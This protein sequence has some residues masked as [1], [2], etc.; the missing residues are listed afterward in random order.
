MDSHCIMRIVTSY[1][2]ALF[3]ASTTPL[4]KFLAYRATL[5]C[6]KTVRCEQQLFI[7][8]LYVRME[9]SMCVRFNTLTRPSRVQCPGLGGAVGLQNAAFMTP[10]SRRD[11]HPQVMTSA[12]RSSRHGN[13]SPA[14]A[15][16]S[17]YHPH[18]A[19]PGTDTYVPPMSPNHP[20]H[21]QGSARHH[22]PSMK[23]TS[24]PQPVW[25]RVPVWMSGCGRIC[26][27]VS[28]F[29]FECLYMSDCAFMR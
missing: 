3:C 29:V 19:P 13:D 24:R 4:V 27:R 12:L 17:H 10:S 26:V 18:L 25:R 8:F 28:C 16:S 11:L 23:N 9:R 7:R 14:S 22:H 5:W 6:F 20:A 1:G 21:R 2:S 15:V